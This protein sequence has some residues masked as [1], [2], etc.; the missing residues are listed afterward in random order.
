M[1][2]L[3]PCP[4]LGANIYRLRLT[5]VW[6]AAISWPAAMSNKPL[7][8]CDLGSAYPRGQPLVGLSIVIPICVFSL[9]R[10]RPTLQ[11][12]SKIDQILMMLPTASS[13][14][15]LASI[16]SSAD[17]CQRCGFQVCWLCGLAPTGN[18][19]VASPLGRTAGII[20][21]REAVKRTALGA[22]EH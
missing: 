11:S 12:R 7:L 18:R 13:I 17:H 2:L 10:T 15:H 5:T 16:I 6:A 22:S 9:L 4:K 3:L 20:R 1:I 21:Q 8:R 19:L 14:D